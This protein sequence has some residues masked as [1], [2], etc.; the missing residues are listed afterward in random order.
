MRGGQM[1]KE[2]RRRSSHVSPTWSGMLG[3]LEL[4]FPTWH[5]LRGLFQ[6]WTSTFSNGLQGPKSY[7]TWPKILFY[8]AQDRRP[9]MHFTVLFNFYN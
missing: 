7:S 5:L 3:L 1:V 9:K 2:A 8:L 4:I 6:K